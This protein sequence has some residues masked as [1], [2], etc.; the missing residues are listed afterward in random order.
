[1]GPAWR[2]QCPKAKEW[3][4]LIQLSACDF[5]TA[6][7]MKTAKDNNLSKVR[8]CL[9]HGAIIRTIKSLFSS[10]SDHLYKR[11]FLSFSLWFKDACGD[12]G[13]PHTKYPLPHKLPLTMESQLTDWGFY[14]PIH[15]FQLFTPSSYPA[16]LSTPSLG[17]WVVLWAGFEMQC[18]PQILK[19]L[20]AI[21]IPR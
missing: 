18:I 3:L 21:R 10:I 4:V 9:M 14:H 20:L 2:Q 7:K 11:L 6:G 19:L 16:F 12:Q 1:M 8:L 13:V 17:T 5:V 15:D